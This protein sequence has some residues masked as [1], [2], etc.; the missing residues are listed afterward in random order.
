MA[1]ALD[2]GILLEIPQPANPLKKNNKHNSGGYCAGILSPPNFLIT[3]GDARVRRS[4][5]EQPTLI[6]TPKPESN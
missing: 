2:I 3:V 4:A 5:S 6:L 1:A